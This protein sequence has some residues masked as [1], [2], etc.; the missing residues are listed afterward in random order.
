MDGG[1]VLEQKFLTSVQT[2]LILS[3]AALLVLVGCASYS[4]PELRRETT[5]V[6]DSGK[7][8]TVLKEISTYDHGARTQRRGVALPV[9][10]YTLEAEDAEYWYFRAPSPVEFRVLEGRRIADQRRIPGGIRIH[11]QTNAA[12]PAGYFDGA[13]GEKEIIAEFTA[14]EFAWM[15]G[16]YWRKN[17]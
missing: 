5:V 10:T 8:F 13:G 12:P 17:F 11:K 16:S 4:V 1:D 15:E 7:N 3:T 14:T 6:E 2:R 9:G